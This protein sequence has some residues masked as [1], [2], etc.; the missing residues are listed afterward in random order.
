MPITGFLLKLQV[1]LL[2]LIGDTIYPDPVHEQESH[3][4][5]DEVQLPVVDTV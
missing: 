4:I 5:D 2:L 1:F 3:I